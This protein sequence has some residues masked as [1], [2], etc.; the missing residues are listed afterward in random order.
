MEFLESEIA[1]VVEAIKR[2]TDPTEKSQLRQKEQQLREEKLLRL[3]LIINQ[4]PGVVFLVLLEL[5][6]CHEF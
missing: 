4:Q 6:I 3:R 2:S 5:A 1:G